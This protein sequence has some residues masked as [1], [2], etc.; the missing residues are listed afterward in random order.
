MREPPLLLLYLLAAACYGLGGAAMKSAGGLTWSRATALV[1]VCFLAGAT[2]QTISLRRGEL[3]AGYIAV[4][5][6]EAVV[7]LGLGLFF[8]AETFS[9]TKALAVALIVTGVWLLRG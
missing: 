7:A 8:Y 3:G 5:G 2:I 1:Y 6:L 9:L 4:L